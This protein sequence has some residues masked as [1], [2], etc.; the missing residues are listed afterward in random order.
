[1]KSRI[2]LR[3]RIARVL[4]P[5]AVLGLAACSVIGTGTGSETLPGTDGSGLVAALQR[6]VE[7]PLS[8]TVLAQVALG[9]PEPTAERLSTLPDGSHTMRLWYGGPDR[10]RVALFGPGSETDVFQ[11]GNVVWRWDSDARVAT[12][13]E[14]AGRSSETMASLAD[15]P[16]Q[17]A[18]LTP[19]QLCRRAL[20]A[21]DAATTMQVHEGRR[22]ADRPTYELVLTPDDPQT[23]VASVHIEVDGTHKVPLGVQVY[24]RQSTE[25]VI[26][27][28]FTSIT[29]KSPGADYFAFTPPPGATV[30]VLSRALA[31]P[32]DG[33]AGVTLPAAVAGV[34]TVG[35]GWSA[36]AEYPRGS[37]RL[38]S[39]VNTDED[40]ADPPT[41]VLGDWGSGRLMISPLLCLLETGD[42]TVY[43]GP[44]DPT[45]LYAAAAGSR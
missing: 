17:F 38:S 23:R 39:V 18:T 21:I 29:F 28:A 34:R 22:V 32:G 42:G 3:R 33:G 4:A 41:T 9:L 24:A 15:A 12:R 10:Q 25:P 36:V 2:P 40:E 19:G 43:V 45:A 44:V 11:A 13:S 35:E 37:S 31:E 27:V 16:L 6:S 30:N 8:G 20:Q 5:G 14:L 26:D 7:T 1:M